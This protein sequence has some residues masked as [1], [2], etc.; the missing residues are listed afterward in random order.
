MY[1][2]HELN[3]GSSMLKFNLKVKFFSLYDVTVASSPLNR[4]SPDILM[5]G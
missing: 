1:A 3:I 4:S 5:R 2:K